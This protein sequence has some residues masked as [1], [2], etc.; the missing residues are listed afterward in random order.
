MGRPEYKKILLVRIDRLGDVVLTTPAVKAIRSAYPNAYIAMM[1][2]PDTALAIKGNPHLNEVIVYDKDGKHKSIIASI[3]FAMGLRKKRFDLAIIFD[4]SNRAHIITYLANIARRIGYDEKP[5]FLLTDRITGTKHEGKKHEVDYNLDMLKVLDIK[6][7][8]REPY[9]VVDL[10]AAAFID[11]LLMGHGIGKGERIITLH[12]GASCPSKM[13][14]V[15][16]FAEL[17]DKLTETYAVNIVVLGGDDPKGIFCV[18]TVRKF[19]TQKALFLAEGLNL[20]HRIALIKR[21]TLLISNDSG[22]M[23][24]AVAVKTPV[25]AIFGRKQPGLS[26]RRWGP[27]GPKDIVL[28][29]DVG[30]IECLAH[31]CKIKF[32]CLTEIKTTEVLGAV[33]KLL[34]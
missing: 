25:V 29:K 22:P 26:P 14:P 31:D 19:M 8:D 5:P 18:N 6:P 3:C 27:I 33:G 11:G 17:A 21:S 32:K 23:H 4:P 7:C 1:V 28:H 20:S 16:R 15:E 13:W 9:I 12:P 24:V 2:K 10:E 30:C 34:R